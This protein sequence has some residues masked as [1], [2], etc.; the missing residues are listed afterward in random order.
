MQKHARI[1]WL[2]GFA[3]ISVLAFPVAE[4]THS[5]DRKPDAITRTPP[6]IDFSR[7]PIADADSKE[8]SDAAARNERLAKSR[9]F[10]NRFSIPVSESSSQ[11][12]VLVDW[13]VGLPALPVKRSS[14][15]VIGEIIKAEAFLSEDKTTIYSEFKFKTEA[16]L[17]PDQI[18]TLAEGRVISAAREGG[19]LRFPSGKVV[20]SWVNHQNMP[21][22]GGKYVLFLTHDLLQ[23]GEDPENLYILTGYELFNGQVTPL[24][25]T[26]PG[27]P[28]SQYKGK[29]ES[30]LL[31]DLMSCLTSPQS[32]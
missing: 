15:V 24:D 1:L 19:R 13:D 21:R 31:R 32:N 22:V 29:N 11:I 23:G 18:L 25:D 10:N 26:L 14:A 30:V 9:K 5:Q 17:K 6:A 7:F 16:V 27:H 12:S 3:I 8:P 4:L 28:I 20:V 2:G